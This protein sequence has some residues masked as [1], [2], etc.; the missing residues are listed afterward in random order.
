MVEIG[1]VVSELRDDWR[2]TWI[3]ESKRRW[4]SDSQ[5]STEEGQCNEETLMIEGTRIIDLTGIIKN[6]ILT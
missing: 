5:L 6:Y 1:V 4:I 2:C 3:L